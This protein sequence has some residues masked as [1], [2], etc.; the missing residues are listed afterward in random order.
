LARNIL[1]RDTQYQQTA[2]VM[3]SGRWGL[4]SIAPGGGL[5][6][7]DYWLAAKTAEAQRTAA[8]ANQPP[9]DPNSYFGNSSGGA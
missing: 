2:P 4:P 9:V 1:A 7:P 6:A 8:A 3:G 5:L